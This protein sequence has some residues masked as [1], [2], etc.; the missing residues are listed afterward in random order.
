MNKIYDNEHD[1]CKK[2]FWMMIL[3]YSSKSPRFIK[4]LMILLIPL[5]LSNNPLT[6][7]SALALLKTLEKNE[8]SALELLDMSVGS[9]LVIIYYYNYYNIK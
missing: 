2:S 5:Q 7:T 6:A 1:L 9:L 3:I 4:F 8:D